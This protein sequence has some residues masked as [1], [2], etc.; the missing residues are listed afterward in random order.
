VVAQRLN[1]QLLEAE[2]GRSLC[3]YLSA[4]VAPDF[5]IGALNLRNIT[6]GELMSCVIGYGMAPEAVGSGFMSEAID[7]IVRVGFEE[8]GLHRLEI[9]IIPRNARSIAV[10]ERCGFEC[11]G[12]SPRYLKIAGRWEDHLRYDKLNEGGR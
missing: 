12:L 10:A 5:V 1:V 11:E 4:K 8:L 9:N 7:R 6:R 2:H 3:T